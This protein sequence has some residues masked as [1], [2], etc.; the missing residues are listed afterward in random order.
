MRADR[1]PFRPRLE[2]M[3]DRVVPALNA[4]LIGMDQGPPLVKVF[5]PGRVEVAS[6]FAF[7]PAVRSGV[8]VGIGDV[9]GDGVNDYICGAGPGGRASVIVVDGTKA[10]Q[11]Q[12]N[13]QIAGSAL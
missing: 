5:A 11:L 2:A 9:N 3:E 12:P 10:K 13:G 8:R 4:G 6:F 1:N 7:D